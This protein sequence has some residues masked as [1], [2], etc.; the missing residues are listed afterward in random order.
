MITFYLIYYN[1]LLFASSGNTEEKYLKIMN[2]LCSVGIVK[3]K[4]FLTIMRMHMGM[5]LGIKK[6][7]AVHRYG[8][9]PG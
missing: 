8:V 6:T 2:W 1:N 7:K 5:D 4:Y 3:L 9:S